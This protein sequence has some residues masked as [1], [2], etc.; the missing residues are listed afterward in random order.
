MKLTLKNKFLLPTLALVIFGMGLSGVI[1]HSLSRSALKSVITDQ[2]E[3]IADTTIKNMDAWLKDRTLD[4]RSWSRQKVYKTALKDTFVG[5]A[6]RNSANL[7]MGLLKDEYKYYENICLADLEGEVVAAANTAAIGKVKVADREYFQAALKGQLLIS[8][9]FKSKTTGSLV[10]IIASP[11]KVK[12]KTTGVI[13][14]IVDLKHINDQFIASVKVGE[15]GYA[16]LYNSDGIVIA[17]PDKTQIMNMNMAEFD[18]GRQM[19]DQKK[20]WANYTFKGVEK[21][22]NYKPYQ[23]MGWT[24]GVEAATKEFYAPVKQLGYINGTVAL[25]VAVIAAIVILLLVRSIVNPINR[26]A[27]G[28][29]EGGDQVASASGQISASSQQLAEGSSEQAASIEETSSSLE[30]MSSMTKQN[31]DNAGQADILMQKANQVVAQANDSMTE[32]TGSM[33]QISKASEETS[34]INKTIDEI[35]F[36]TNLL[37]LN[38]AVEAARA[39]EAGAGF[40]VV[41]DEVRNLAM[42]AADAAKNTAE[43]IEDTVKKVD[44]GTVLVNHTNGAFSKV[45]ESVSKVGELVSEIAAASNEQAQGIDQVNT[46]VGEMDK[47]TQS[48]AAVAEES[49]SASEEMSAQAEKM[50]SIVGELV[51]L[52]GG[53]SNYHRKVSDAEI[54]TPSPL[55]R[56]DLGAF[57]KNKPVL[58]RE[59]KETPEQMIPLDGMELKD[60]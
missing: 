54:K 6:A 29:H 26:I 25:S 7:N 60:I 14:C 16:F 51:A 40:A 41:A 3:H 36:Q 37:A 39:G 57:K 42:R 38:A 35:A 12:S 52:V 49:A 18:F 23:R 47:V 33:E 48:N 9:V 10:F 44:D 11:V 5:K 17:H 21:I 45:A 4:V 19:M 2:I 31:A 59:K 50:K 15:T 22:V 13:F 1:S 30:E 46:A 34:K 24:L 56:N 58:Y 32:L 53:N 8:D 43:L 55:S 27:R 28:L 20:G